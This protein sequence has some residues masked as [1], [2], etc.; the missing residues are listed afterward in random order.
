MFSSQSCIEMKMSQCSSLIYP[1]IF[2]IHQ[3]LGHDSWLTD[4]PRI[5]SLEIAALDSD[6]LS[7]MWYF[8]KNYLF[9][10]FNT[11]FLTAEVQTNIYF[12]F[13]VLYCKT[14]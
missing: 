11:S 14:S 13:Y 9:Y 2:T 6:K 10:I 1:V 4:G 3:T 12:C 7:E 5:H 8:I